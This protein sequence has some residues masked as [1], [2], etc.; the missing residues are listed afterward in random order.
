M[1]HPAHQ[2][3]IYTYRIKPEREETFLTLLG[4]QWPLLLKRH[5]VT[6]VP[7]LVYRGVDQ[8]HQPVV[9]E[10]FTWE[11]RRSI[12]LARESEEIVAHWNQME[13]C[14]EARGDQ[15]AK[16]MLEVEPITPGGHEMLRI[17]LREKRL[18]YRLNSRML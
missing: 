3:V 12:G 16:E 14:L 17:P 6:E 9:V 11:S 1:S 2:S 13:A 7:P 10:V 5:L 18:G 4:Q 15:A 8:Y